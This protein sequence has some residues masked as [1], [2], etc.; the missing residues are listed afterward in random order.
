M[1]VWALQLV[2]PNQPKLLNSHIC[3]FDRTLLTRQMAAPKARGWTFIGF[4]EGIIEAAVA[5]ETGLE[6]NL[7]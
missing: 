7:S 5:A 3:G 2:I 6:C 4:A 1:L